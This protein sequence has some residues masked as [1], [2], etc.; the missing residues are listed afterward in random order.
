VTLGHPSLEWPSASDV[1]GGAVTVFGGGARP[2]TLGHFVRA[3]RDAEGG[4]QYVHERD[5]AEAWYLRLTIGLD[6]N[7][8][9]DK[10]PPAE[11]GYSIKL[12][13]GADD[14]AARRFKVDI[15][16]NGDPDQT[17]YQVLASALEQLAV[18]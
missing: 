4:L 17:P 3:R 7:D 14:G 10:L 1:D 11:D 12:L 6:I 8:D 18:E 9:R 2:T 5:E 16:W 13:V 15:D